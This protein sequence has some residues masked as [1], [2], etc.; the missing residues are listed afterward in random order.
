[1]RII[2]PCLFLPLFVLLCVCLRLPVNCSWNCVYIES[3]LKP[4]SNSLCVYTHL[5]SS[6]SDSVFT[7]TLIY[8]DRTPTYT[9]RTHRT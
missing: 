8:T 4:E 7:H 6:D 1:M 2:I 5:A 3:N 9:V